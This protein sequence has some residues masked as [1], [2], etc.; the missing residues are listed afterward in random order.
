MRVCLQVRQQSTTH[1]LGRPTTEA[2]GKSGH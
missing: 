1:V 2:P